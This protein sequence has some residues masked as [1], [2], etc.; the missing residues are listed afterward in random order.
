[1]CFVYDRSCT[2][3]RISWPR[4]RKQHQCCECRETIAVGERYRYEWQALSDG[5]MWEGKLCDACVY[6]FAL[7][8]AC[9]RAD[10]CQDNESWY[11]IGDGYM[12]DYARDKGWRGGVVGG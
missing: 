2:A 5:E 9:E 1:M 8:Y 11:P 4:A 3:Q 10:G 7:L 6:L 12:R